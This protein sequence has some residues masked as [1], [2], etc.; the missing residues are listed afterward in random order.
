MDNF[1]KSADNFTM[2]LRYCALFQMSA[3][4]RPRNHLSQK[5]L[6]QINS[7]G[8]STFSDFQ[9]CPTCVL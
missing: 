7:T 8:R 1:V 5:K 2:W 6:G 4:T 3:L 9:L